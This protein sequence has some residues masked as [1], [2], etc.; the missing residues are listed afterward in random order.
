M[1]FIR[2]ILFCAG[3]F[4][5]F[6]GRNCPQFAG[7]IS[8]YMLF[9]IFPLM[10]AIISVLGYALG[11][12]AEA[13]QL[14]L[15]RSIAEVLPVSSEFVSETV[16]GLV[17]ARAITGVASVFGL[18][19]GATAVFGAIRKGINAAWGIRKTRPFLKERLIDF[20]LVLGAGVV[21]L[22]VLFSAP[23]LALLREATQ[24]LAPKSELINGLV[25]S[26]VAKL[27]LPT[28]SF[29]AFLVLYR[30]LPNTDAS[31]RNVWP[32]ALLASLAFGGANLGFVW[33]VRT[34]PIYNVVYGPIGALLALLTWVYLSAIILLF[35]ALLA[36]RYSAY[37][38]SL[39]AE[40]QSLKLL[41][42]GF[43]RVRLR[44]VESTG[45]G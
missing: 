7:A 21:L 36:S 45:T 22:A 41:L 23:A 13:E 34:F 3:A 31:V 2:F 20:A 4:N 16:E 25:W 27:L 29:V 26:L 6:L 42:T 35:G 11:P 14:E 43:W 18:L 9:S 5:D 15:A 30:F 8:F 38:S 17:S 33:Y 19:W 24:V 28:L 1:V 32:W 44:V 37:V 10:L 39:G 40:T 12:R